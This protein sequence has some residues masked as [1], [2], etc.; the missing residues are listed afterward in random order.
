MQADPLYWRHVPVRVAASSSLPDAH[1]LTIRGRRR[2]AGAASPGLAGLHCRQLAAPVRVGQPR[3]PGHR[4]RWHTRLRALQRRPGALA[5]LWQRATRTAVNVVKPRKSGT[6]TLTCAVAL[7]RTVLAPRRN[8]TLPSLAGSLGATT[9]W[10]SPVATWHRRRA[11]CCVPPLQCHQQHSAFLSRL[12][13]CACAYCS[14]SCAALIAMDRWISPRCWHGRGSLRP[15]NLSRGCPAARRARPRCSSCWR[16]ARWRCGTSP[17]RPSPRPA[18]APRRF[19][20]A[21]TGTRQPLWRRF[22]RR[23]GTSVLC[24]PARPLSMVG[25][26]ARVRGGPP[27]LSLS[28]D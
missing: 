26:A 10:W 25:C 11:R 1:W 27:P 24:C 22:V 28:D 3:W 6:R 19:C 21:S 2:P 18:A 12:H 15:R 13:V 20:A 23:C 14:Y 8:A 9:R 4:G 16:T 5:L 7:P 17:S